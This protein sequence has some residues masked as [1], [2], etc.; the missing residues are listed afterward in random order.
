MA[1]QQSKQLEGLWSL[2]IG[3]HL[4]VLPAG[5]VVLG[6]GKLYGGDNQYFYVGNYEMNDNNINGVLYVTHYNDV[7]GDLFGAAENLPIRISGVFAE[8]DIDLRGV[9]NNHPEESLLFRLTKRA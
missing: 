8:H 5:I 4:G 9:L 7:P 2:E 1:M 3:T 6:T